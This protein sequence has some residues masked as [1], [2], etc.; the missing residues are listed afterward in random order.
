MLLLILVEVEGQHELLEIDRRMRRRGSWMEWGSQSRRV[1]LTSCM[2]E[3]SVK[4]ADNL[5]HAM[6]CAMSEYDDNTN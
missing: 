4:H 5:S 2:D 3:M 6:W 1:T